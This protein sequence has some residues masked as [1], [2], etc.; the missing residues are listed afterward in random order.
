MQPPRQVFLKEPQFA[1][2]GKF[3]VTFLNFIEFDAFHDTTQSFQ[4]S[5]GGNTPIQ[6]SNTYAGTHGRTNFTARNTQIGLA[7]DGP[8]L[9]GM[10][11]GGHCRLDFN[12]QQ[13]GTPQNGT[14]RVLVSELGDSAPF[15]LLRHAED[16][17]RRRARWAHVHVVRKPAILLPGV[18]DVPGHSGRGLHQNDTAALFAPVRVIACRCVRRGGDGQAAPAGRGVP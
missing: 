12:G 3:K 18:S 14:Q 15:P 1:M 4:D 6:L 10:T 11:A 16:A 17:L 7:I 9:W 5:F 2:F 8:E 13:P